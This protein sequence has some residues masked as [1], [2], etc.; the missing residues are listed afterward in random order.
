MPSV[1]LPIFI[2]G[3]LL[4]GERYHPLLHGAVAAVQTARLPRARLYDLGY[5]PML[6]DAPEGEV[7]GLLLYLW[8]RRYDGIV[9]LLD[10]VEGFGQANWGRP[11]FRRERRV[12][13][14]TGGRDVIAWVYIGWPLYVAGR[15]PIGADWKSYVLALVKSV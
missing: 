6:I 3:T 15:Q 13:V 1:Q 2:Y 11:L 8:P 7:R 5:F 4:A 9:A 10:R 14:T 12:I